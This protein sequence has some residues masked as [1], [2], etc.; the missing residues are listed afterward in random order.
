L[1]DENVLEFVSTLSKQG[2]VS[3][4]EYRQTYYFHGYFEKREEAHR[5]LALMNT[6]EK[7]KEH[8]KISV[9]PTFEEVYKEWIEHIGG[10]KKQLSKSTYSTYNYGYKILKNIHSKRID[11][12][13]PI[14]IQSIL[15]EHN[16]Y[17]KSSVNAIKK[18]LNKIEEFALMQR[19]IEEGYMKYL[20]FEYSDQKHTIH[21]AYLESEI[22]LLWENVTVPY[23][24]F[25]LITIYTGLRPSE[26][27]QIKNKNVFLEDRYMIGG[28]KTAAGI[29][30]TIPISDRI[31]NLI[32]QIYDPKN[33]Y[34][35]V[36]HL[37]YDGLFSHFKSLMERLNLNHL[38][39]DGRHT[40]ATLMNRYNAN[41]VCTKIIMGH[42]LNGNI[43]EGVYTHKELSDLLEAVN[44]I[45]V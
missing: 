45:K 35:Y 23:V 21:N 7:V 6:D 4:I 8:R 34:L 26:L 29:D 37:T 17:S 2:V 33:E 24:D 32:K 28:M 10:L 41:S 27:L 39:H 40:F 22:S 43:T 12:I 38:L 1:A 5:F 20:V 3:K 25:I 14:E 9:A 11:N 13:K 36:P 18:V 15:N 44:V 31:Y 42:S 16:T 19:Y 30:R